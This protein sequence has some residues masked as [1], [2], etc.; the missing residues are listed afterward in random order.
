MRT[1]ITQDSTL[2]RKLHIRQCSPL[3][4]KE[5]LQLLQQTED[6]RCG[7]KKNADPHIARRTKALSSGIIRGY[8]THSYQLVRAL[9]S[10][11]GFF[12]EKTL[13]FVYDLYR[14]TRKVSGGPYHSRGQKLTLIL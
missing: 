13:L 8:H 7:E 2:Y 12:G 4:K 5:E 14:Y 3:V 1:N 10:S 11:G 9:H 6:A